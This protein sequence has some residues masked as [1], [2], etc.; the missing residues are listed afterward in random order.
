MSKCQ[1]FLVA[2]RSVSPGSLQ[3]LSHR[4]RRL[5]G[6]ANY[7]SMA[8]RSP[9]SAMRRL[10]SL[11]DDSIRSRIRKVGIAPPARWWQKNQ[12][13]DEAED[14]ARRWFERIERAA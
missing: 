6:A 12:H 13:R 8:R 11:A 14:L 10:L 4:R 7:A 1:A 5:E 2:A 3:G 9:S